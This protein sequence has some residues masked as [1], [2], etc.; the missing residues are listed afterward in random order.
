MTKELKTALA[1]ALDRKY[2]FW[3]QAESLEEIF[4]N[5]LKPV[6]E[7]S[8]KSGRDMVLQGYFE[9][10][11]QHRQWHFFIVKESSE[12]CDQALLTGPVDDAL[13]LESDYMRIAFF[14]PSG[15]LKV[16]SVTRRDDGYS[17]IQDLYVAEGGRIDYGKARVAIAEWVAANTDR[18]FYQRFCHETGQNG[19]KNLAPR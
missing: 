5:G 10:S 6:L 17:D 7:L 14:G 19:P 8:Q 2:G 4:V 16:E 12:N 18:D 15:T 1:E 13:L 11:E 3:E 9:K